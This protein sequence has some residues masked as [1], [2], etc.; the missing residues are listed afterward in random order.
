M[1]PLK[2]GTLAS[3]RDHF[4]QKKSVDSWD[5]LRYAAMYVCVYAYK[6]RYHA[7]EYIYIYIYMCVY[8]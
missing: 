3:A 7:H 8:L 6:N 1:E 2:A 5:L 4:C